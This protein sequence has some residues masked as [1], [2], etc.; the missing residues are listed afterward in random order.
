MNDVQRT[1][2]R[3][4]VLGAGHVGPIVARLAVE[5]G[6]QT[7]IATSGDP[8]DIALTVQVL[9]PGAQPRWLKDAAADAD[10][11]VLAVPLHRF[12]ELDPSLLAGKVVIDM[13]NYWPEVNGYLSEFDR[14]DLTSSELIALQLADSRV[15]KTLNHLGYH[16]IDE[17]ARPGDA[18]LWAL[19]VAGDDG[20]AV[21]LVSEFVDRIG[22]HPVVVGRLSAGRILEP[23][24]PVFGRL[25]SRDDL[26]RL[27]EGV[28]A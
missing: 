5:A 25:I 19:G 23:T 1:L 17:E 15:V 28:A 16:Q 18:G 14:A 13:M 10:L 11:V 20:A 27:L 9:A 22:F 6:Y 26:E 2:P 3:V 21:R 4:A 24:G 7:A 8:E 12:G